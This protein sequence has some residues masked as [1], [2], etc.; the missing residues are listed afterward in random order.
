[1]REETRG[2]GGGAFFFL[3]VEVPKVDSPGL[4]AAIP[5]SLIWE[6]GGLGEF[7]NLAGNTGLCK[8]LLVGES[9]LDLGIGI[10]RL[11]NGG[12]RGSKG[13]CSLPKSSLEDVAIAKL[14]LIRR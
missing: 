1:M 7:K 14:S 13:N 5:D 2:G 11:G 8:K 4:P 9:D 10:V 6:V 3:N 12:G